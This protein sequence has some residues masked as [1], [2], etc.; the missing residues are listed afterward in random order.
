MAPLH[1]FRA[2]ASPKQGIVTKANLYRFG[3]SLREMLSRAAE[4]EE[5]KRRKRERVHEKVGRE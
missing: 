3:S 2:G 4:R 1:W 5:C